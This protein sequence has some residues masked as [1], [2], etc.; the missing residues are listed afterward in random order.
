MTGIITLPLVSLRVSSSES[1]E[2][3]TQLMFGER[4]EVFEVGERWLHVR[5]LTDNCVG[6]VDSKMVQILSPEEEKRLSN[7]PVFCIPVPFLVCDKPVSRQKMYLPG[8]SYFPSYNY[9][10]CIIDDEIYQINMS[11]N[12]SKPSSLS[13]EITNN[14]LQYLNA[15]Y[16][17]GG[18]SIM[19]IDCSGLVQVVFAMSGIQLPRD[20]AHQVEVGRVIDFLFEAQ[21]GD[22][23]FFENPEREIVHV[24]ILLNTHQIIHASGCVK[25]DPIDSQGVIS[26]KT[27]DYTHTLRV[28]KRVI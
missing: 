24:G 4:V 11:S 14:T 26:T 10:R 23:V 19:G 22:L 28:I 16:L 21:P 13:Q 18:K 7:S 25:I 3:S 15:P 17:L 27:G 20:A 2:L 8:G 12:Q 1:S 6:W 5:N 9:G